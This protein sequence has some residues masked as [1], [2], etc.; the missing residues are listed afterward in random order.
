[1]YIPAIVGPMDAPII[2]INVDIPSDTP[3]DCFG[4][5]SITIFIAPTFVKERPADKIAKF[6]ATKD[7][8]EWNKKSEQKPVAPI[9]LPAMIGFIEPNLEII[10]PDVGPN[11]NRTNAKDS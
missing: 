11:I 8:V 9:I 4:V 5:A 1:M 6:T 7:S 3:T 2:L 10:K